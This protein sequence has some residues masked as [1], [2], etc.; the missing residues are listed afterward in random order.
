M[1]RRRKDPNA[2]KLIERKGWTALRLLR[3]LKRCPE[4]HPV[5]MERLIYR[6][7]DGVLQIDQ[8]E[9]DLGDVYVYTN[10]GDVPRIVLIAQ[11]D[12]I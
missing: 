9:I 10:P 6:R 5:R 8:E 4:E 1:P 2:P 3:F 11:E 12:R 7:V